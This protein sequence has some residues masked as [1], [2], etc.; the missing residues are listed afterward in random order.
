MAGR[1]SIDLHR[2]AAIFRD[3]RHGAIARSSSD[4]R[5]LLRSEELRDRP[6]F[7]GW[8][9]SFAILA[10]HVEPSRSLDLHRT[11]DASLGSGSS[12]IGRRKSIN[13]IA[14]RSRS[15]GQDA[16]DLSLTLATHLDGWIRIARTTI[17]HQQD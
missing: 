10:T 17:V 11:V 12:S 6:I 16:L 1:G 15:E 3:W 7:I 4:G 9:R 13:V 5:D 8:P 2:M 14:G